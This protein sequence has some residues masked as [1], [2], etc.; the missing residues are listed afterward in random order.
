MN[1]N[2]IESQ[3]TIAFYDNLN[4]VEKDDISDVDGFRFVLA[5]PEEEKARFDGKTLDYNDG[6][7][8]LC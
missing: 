6:K 4:Y 1:N 8:V 3:P 2:I 5:V 7:F